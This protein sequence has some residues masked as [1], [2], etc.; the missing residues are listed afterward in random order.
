MQQPP[1]RVELGV[2]AMKGYS[3]F[4][5][6]Y[7]I[8]GASPSDCLVPYPGHSLGVGLLL[9]RDAASVFWL[10]QQKCREKERMSEE[11]K[12]RMSEESKRKDVWRIKKKGCLKNQKERMP[13]ESK[14]KDVWRIKKKGCL[15]NQKE[16]MSE[17]S[18]RKDVWI[19]TN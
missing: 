8:I 18:K 15:K 19:I 5:Q 2:M 7:S 17:E 4:P 14:R 1:G 11:S 16:R 13:E 12:E 10:G 9:C 6:S 3:E